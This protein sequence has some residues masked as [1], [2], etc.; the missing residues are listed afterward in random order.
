MFPR[1]RRAFNFILQLCS[2]LGERDN[3]V[4]DLTQRV[5]SA[6]LLSDIVQSYMRLNSTFVAVIAHVNGPPEGTCP[7][8]EQFYSDAHR[9]RGQDDVRPYDLRPATGRN[10]TTARI[11]K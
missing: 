4:A 1:L 11:I 6:F 8:G 9:S 10:S 3:R 5:V 2:P 7:V